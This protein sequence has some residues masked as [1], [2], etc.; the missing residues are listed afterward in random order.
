[1]PSI[2]HALVVEVSAKQA[3]ELAGRFAALAA[4]IEI[5]PAGPG[6]CR[7]HIFL[8]TIGGR[9]PSPD[10]TAS[11]LRRAGLDP[12]LDVRVEPIEDGRWVERYQAGLR[13]FPF[14]ARFVI[15]PDGRAPRDLGDRQTLLLVPGR[16]FGTGEHP[17]T[18]LCAEALE[19]AVIRGSRWLD[20]G[21]GSGILSL[22]AHH[23]GAGRVLAL[24]TDEEAVEVAREVFEAN[25]LA[26]AIDARVG[27]SGPEAGDGWDGLVANVHV[28]F[29]LD[30]AESIASRLVP[31]G[32]L[33]ASGFLTEDLGPVAAAMR[34]AGL[35]EIGRE[36]R[37]PWAALVAQREV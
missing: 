6:H 7:L 14:G 9:S 33:I 21:C 23:C 16:A 15:H 36:E 35:S 18:Q 4:G 31:G 19:R 10:E 11:M 32:H 37:A 24:D 2:W 25:R 26:T 5:R 34:A 27:S 28:S 30:T 12:A 1:M 8:E 17:T 29:F 20:V 3:E 22:V 13:P